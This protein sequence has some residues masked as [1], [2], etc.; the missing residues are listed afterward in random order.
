MS[1]VAG[2][3]LAFL[4][5]GTPAGAATSGAGLYLTGA[6]SGHGVGMSQYG[7]AGYALHGADYQEILRDYYTWTTLGHVDPNRTVTVLLRASG[8][9]AFS[10]ATTI[11][12]SKLK[13][14]PLWSYN[15]V[16]A[17][18][19]RATRTTVKLR[20]RIGRTYCMKKKEPSFVKV[21]FTLT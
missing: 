7:A 4:I 16:P 11:T 18:A 13:L 14:N 6:G 19:D 12:G 9:A 5:C 1:A 15:V 3:M 8:S 17:G 10:G 20:Y 21:S 2:V